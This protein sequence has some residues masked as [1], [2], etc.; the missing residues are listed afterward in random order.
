V[1]VWLTTDKHKLSTEAAKALRNASGEGKGVAL[2]STSLWEIA[3]ITARGGFRLPAPLGEYLG[4][5]EAAFVV[6]P[7]TSAI[8]ERSI[9]FTDKYPKD[10]SDRIIGATGLVHGLA[11]VTAD[12]K[13]RK[14]GEV[15]C[16]W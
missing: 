14:S 2:A 10:P 9:S 8:A 16:I 6:L 15:R 11:L 5:L 12:K 4:Y 13:I 1:A 3:M 7:I